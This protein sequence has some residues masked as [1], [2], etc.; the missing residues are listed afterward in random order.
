MSPVFGRQTPSGDRGEAVREA[1]PETLP[2]SRDPS[3]PCPRCGRISNFHHVGDLPV[4]FG[5]GY[6]MSHDGTRRPEELDRVSVLVCLGCHQGTTVIEE[7][8]V[9]DHPARQGIG[10]GGTITWRGVHWWPVPGSAD[11]DEAIP[12]ALRAAY[13]EATRALAARAPRA[14]AV[15]LRRTVEGIVR[16]KGDEA[17]LKALEKS[18]AAALG[19]MADSRHLDGSLA[20]WATE[21]RIAGNVGAHFDPMDDV[22][23]EEAENLSR[24]TRQLLHYVYEMPA[25]IR[26]SREA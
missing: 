5:T 10:T 24:L 7:Q 23:E 8:W 6:T 25:Q 26:R 14:A 15:M 18:L 17:A 22:S 11:L 16:D 20:D 1:N 21:V 12:P 13:Q 3:G 19:S 4:S 9:G 2:D